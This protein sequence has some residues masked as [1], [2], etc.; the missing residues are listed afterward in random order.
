[1]RNIKYF[2]IRISNIKRYISKNCDII[3][4]YQDY[5][6]NYTL[7]N[8]S[9]L[10]DKIKKSTFSLIKN[11]KSYCN[12]KLQSDI[13]SKNGKIQLKNIARLYAP[14]NAFEFVSNHDRKYQRRTIKK[15]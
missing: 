3:K 11:Y 1:M 14:K 6:H 9:V 10:N 7:V 13:E 2:S 4:P 8:N 5:K 12:K 15:I